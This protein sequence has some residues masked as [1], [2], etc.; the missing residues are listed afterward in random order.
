[1]KQAPGLRLVLLNTRAPASVESLVALSGGGEV[2]L[3]IA[4]LEGLGGVE[5]LLQRLPAARLCF[6]S[7]AP[8]YC[9]ESAALKLKESVLSE[10]QLRAIC[11][12]NAARLL[13]PKHQTS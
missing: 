13:G 6:G 4:M 10:E 8:F 2:Y 11:R 12:A 7:H 5:R 1:M 9:F 3:E